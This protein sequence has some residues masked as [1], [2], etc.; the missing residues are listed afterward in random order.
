MPDSPLHALR[1]YC[2]HVIGEP[3]EVFD[4]DAMHG[5]GLIGHLH[6]FVLYTSTR[7]VLCCACAVCACACSASVEVFVLH[8]L[9][10]PHAHMQTQP[11]TRMDSSPGTE[12]AA[13]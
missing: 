6:C 5:L 9:H 3:S 10:S 11:Q 7:P 8:H 2:C 1:V 13:R 12:D 4:R